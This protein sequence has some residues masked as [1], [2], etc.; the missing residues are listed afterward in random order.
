MIHVRYILIYLRLP[1]TSTIQTVHVGKYSI[2][3]SYGIWMM[4]SRF[5]A[6]ICHLYN[7]HRKN[8]SLPWAGCYQT[9]H[10]CLLKKNMLKL[11]KHPNCCW[12]KKSITTWD[13][14]N[15]VNNKDT[16]PTNWCRISSTNS[17]WWLN[18]PIWKKYATVKLVNCLPQSSGWKFKIWNQHLH[19]AKLSLWCL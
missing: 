8:S 12:W 15:P 10:R 7:S 13:V 6:N 4:S 19:L 17:S 16:R 3:R 1:K 11:S 5:S 14:S 2:Y 9:T 18:Q